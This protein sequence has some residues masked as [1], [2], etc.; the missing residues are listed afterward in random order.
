MRRALALDPGNPAKLTSL[1]V[2][3]LSLGERVDGLFQL[4]EALRVDPH[5]EEAHYNIGVE[6][7]R[8]DPEEA[9]RSFRTARE[10]DPH[11]ALAHRELAHLLA[12]AKTAVAPAFSVAK[13]SLGA[14]FED[15]GDEV[16]ARRLY[17]AALKDD[18]NDEIAAEKLRNL[19]LKGK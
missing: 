18:P 19:D 15:R 12:G 7:A 14:L 17:E 2:G 8:D 9:E 4:R 6:V 5:Y 11:Y 16:S 10:I 13:W 1:G 3:L